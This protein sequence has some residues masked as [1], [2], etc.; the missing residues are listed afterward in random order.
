MIHGDWDGCIFNLSL[1]VDWVS[2]FFC[3]PFDASKW[4]SGLRK[5]SADLHLW[6]MERF[7]AASKFQV[8]KPT[9]IRVCQG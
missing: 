2:F 1:A 4:L 7:S 9:I 3:H 5:T 8:K 6:K